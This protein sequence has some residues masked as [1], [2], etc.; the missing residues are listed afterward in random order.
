MLKS[1]MRIYFALLIVLIIEITGHACKEAN[2]M[3][4]KAVLLI[5]DYNAG[6]QEVDIPG[7]SHILF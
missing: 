5:R 4:Q 3:K 1:T 7:K 2:K 6:N